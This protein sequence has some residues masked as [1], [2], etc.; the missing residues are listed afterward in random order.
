MQQIRNTFMP[1]HMHGCLS[2]HAYSNS[3][4]SHQIQYS[5][6]PCRLAHAYGCPKLHK[7]PNAAHNNQVQIMQIGPYV[8]ASHR[9]L[10]DPSC[11]NTRIQFTTIKFRSCRL[12]L[13]LLYPIVARKSNSQGVTNLTNMHEYLQIPNLLPAPIHSCS[14]L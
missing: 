14:R 10:E 11:A 5:S 1:I 6:L 4:L 3:V 7:Y 2:L 9:R 13:A 8:V 12:V